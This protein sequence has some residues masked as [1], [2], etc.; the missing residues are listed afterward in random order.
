[1]THAL[2][3]TVSR[4]RARAFWLVATCYVAVILTTPLALG[5]LVYRGLEPVLTAGPALAMAIPVAALLFAIVPGI[6]S[7]PH[8]RWIVPARMPTDVGIRAYFHRRLYGLCWTSLYYNQLLY[9]LVLSMP[10]LKLAVFRL[11][12]YRGAA[13]F[14]VYPDT[15]IRD[16]PLLKIGDGAYLSNKATIGTNMILQS[17]QI[18]VDEVEVGAGATVGHLACLA[19]GARCEADSEVGVATL[20]GLRARIGPGARIGPR[21]M[22]DHGA[23]VGSKANVEA[24]AYVG[25]ATMIGPEVFV[26]AME[27]IRSRARIAAQADLVMNMGREACGA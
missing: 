27:V 15:W 14:T 4:V 7:L 22:I 3:L 20:V 26:P 13:R 17:R 9:W 16:L 21:C 24:G 2:D 1:M 8:Q 12:G 18:V 19:P 5:A 11:F 10:R 25:C 23:R 6:L